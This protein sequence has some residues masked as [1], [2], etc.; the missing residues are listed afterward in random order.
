[1]L[2]FILFSMI[3]T[4]ISY[5]SWRFLDSRQWLCLLAVLPVLVA[6]AIGYLVIWWIGVGAYFIMVLSLMMSMSTLYT[7][8]FQIITNGIGHIYSQKDEDNL[9]RFEQ[10]SLMEMWRHPRP[11]R[12]WGKDSQ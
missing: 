5:L 3:C 9:K 1:M 8:L 12:D 10:T 2:E 11:M 4:L 7:S 6:S